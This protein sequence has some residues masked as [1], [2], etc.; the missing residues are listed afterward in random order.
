MLRLFSKDDAACIGYGK[1]LLAF[2]EVHGLAILNGMPKRPGLRAFTCYFLRLER[3]YVVGAN[4]VVSRW[5][6]DSLHSGCHMHSS[7]GCPQARLFSTS[8]VTRGLT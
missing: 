7:G 2:G 8:D 3:F 5:E 4:L 6:K 1:H